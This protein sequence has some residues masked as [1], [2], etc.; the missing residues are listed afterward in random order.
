[1]LNNSGESGVPG[2]PAKAAGRWLAILAMLFLPAGAVSQEPA[3]S[4]GLADIAGQ[5]RTLEARLGSALGAERDSIR[6][7]LRT[8]RR[9]YREGAWQ[10]VDTL[11]PEDAADRDAGAGILEGISAALGRQLEAGEE[12]IGELRALTD[13]SDG[14]AAAQ[15]REDLR[16]AESHRMELLEAMVT[17]ITRMDRYGLPSGE[18]AARAGALLRNRAQLLSGRIELQSLRRDD[19]AVTMEG[20]DPESPEYADARR[21]RIAIDAAVVRSGE[22]LSGVANLLERLGTDVAEY[23]QTAFMATGDLSAEILDRQVVGSVLARWLTELRTGFLRHG[24]DILTRLVVVAVILAVFWLL[25]RVV[26]AMVRRGLDNLTGEMSTLARDFLV[27]L[28]AKAVLITGILVAL[29][30]FG[31]QIGPLLAGLGIVGFIVGFALQDT[32]SNFASGIMILIYRPFDVGDYVE[33]AGVQGEVKH[34]NLVS[35][36]VHTPQNHRLVIP[37]NRIWGNIIR[38]ITSQDMRRVDLSVGVSY[39]DDI[40]RVE[41]LLAEIVAAEN[42]VKFEPEP[43]I[44][45][46]N[47]GE[48]AVEF[49][50]R[51]WVDSTDYMGVF[52]DLTRRIKIRFDEE[53]ISF[54][55]PQRTVHLVSAD[56]DDE[57]S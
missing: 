6:Q 46:H 17:N 3:A 15:A 47:L 33:A 50:V 25:A 1:M 56:G 30:Q 22:R 5:I 39:E 36:T 38:N 52:W 19:I 54:P 43:T 2:R 28:S 10:Y 23:R 24:P 42:R 40:E 20:L 49:T 21:Q 37:N 53:G 57:R 11:D 4:S 9:L 55:Y 48:S 29:S 51:V 44:R 27:G 35:T 8:Q 18:D 16:L 32:L 41:A 34:M 12:R 7:R 31:L 26:R 14:A 45:L 13:S